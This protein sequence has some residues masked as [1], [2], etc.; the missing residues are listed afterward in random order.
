M[1]INKIKI[2]SK[3]LPVI[4]I[5]MCY[6]CCSKVEAQGFSAMRNA[7]PAKRAQ[8]QTDIMKS[9]LKLDSGQVTKVRAINLK[10]AE[11][12]EP[13]LKSNDSRKKRI[14]AAMTLQQAKDTEL[15]GVFT[16]DQYKQYTE[17]ESEIKS[18]FSGSIK[19]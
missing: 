13:I 6:V 11:K 8:I 2:A 7:P 12:F 10:Y 15:K 1:S 16:A 14:R 4:L 19:N 17:F 3:I 5:V 9:K 18:K